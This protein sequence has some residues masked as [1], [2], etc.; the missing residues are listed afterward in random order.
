MEKLMRSLKY[1]LAKSF[2]LW[3]ILLSCFLLNFWAFITPAFEFPDEQGHIAM[4]QFMAEQDRLPVGKELDLSQELK[5]TEDLLGTFRDT[6]GNNSYTYHPDYHVEYTGSLL[7]KYEAEI[8]LLNTATYRRTNVWTEAARYPR[9]YYDYESIWYKLAGTG[10]II[11][12]TYVMRIGGLGLALLTAYVIYQVGILIFAKKSYAV[13]LT[14]LVMLQ[15]MYSFLSAGVNSD[16]LHNLIFA[17]VLY[18]CI[19]IIKNGNS[20]KLLVGT[21]VLVGLDIMSKPQGFVGI[22]IIISAILINFIQTK[23]WRLIAILAAIG[24]G[25]VIF[26]F[27]PWNPYREWINPVTIHN[28]NLLEFIK[29]SAN[30]LISQNIVWYWGVFKWLGMVLPPMYWQ[31]ANRIVLTAAL[32][33]FVYLW[34]VITKRKIVANPA[35]TLFLL[36]ATIVYI[37][38]IYWFDWQFTKKIG[39]SLGVQARYFFPTISAQMALLMI[40]ILS[41]G[42]NA[43]I[44]T[45]LRCGLVLFIV[46]MQLGGLWRLITSY[47]DVSSVQTF[48]TQ[49]SQYKPAFAKGDWWYLWSG[50]YIVSI[51]YL[52]FLGMVG[53]KAKKKSFLD[54]RKL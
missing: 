51:L 7:G 36:L 43:K 33:L 35:I 20:P 27:S 22:P 13:T 10:D 3:N 53:I 4:V 24:M 49:A 39:Y 31:V 42:W 25:L 30:K 50:L 9:L 47:Y 15:P 26:A 2:A 32:G 48:I 6:H 1:L 28:S 34:K 38:A 14:M 44:R 37:G 41:L 17:A 46:W 40:G 5:Y 54:R 18:C 12:R 29:F 23:R 19:K 52:T 21:A 45:W 11:L 16:N 8:A